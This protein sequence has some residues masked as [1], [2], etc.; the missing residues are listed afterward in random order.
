MLLIISSFFTVD[1]FLSRVGAVYARYQHVWDRRGL[2]APIVAILW[3][4]RHW[5]D[6]IFPSPRCHL[7]LTKTGPLDK[8]GFRTR[9][10]TAE[11]NDLDRHATSSVLDSSDRESFTSKAGGLVRE[12]QRGRLISG[13]ICGVAAT[14][15]CDFRYLR[16]LPRRGRSSLRQVNFAA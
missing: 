14:A 4:Y 1:V 3:S 13:R 16:H 8:P 9:R 12:Q 10:S 5:V 2:A 6:F 15:S 11:S 7:R